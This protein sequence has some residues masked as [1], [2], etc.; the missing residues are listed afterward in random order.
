MKKLYQQ[1]NELN[2]D[3]EVEPM[4]VDEVE[5]K[6][7]KNAVLM[8]KKKSSL[9]GKLSTSVIL[10]ASVAIISITLN[11]T[12]PVLAAKLPIIGNI[13]EL[14]QKENKAYVFDEYNEYSTEIG[15]TKESSGIEITITNAVYDKESVTIAYTMKSEVDLGE[16]P[17]LD[18]P[19]LIEELDYGYIQGGLITEKIGD[20]EYAGLYITDLMSGVK[21]EKIHFRW[22]GNAVHSD[23]LKKPIEGDWSF[24]FTLDAL[25]SKERRLKN[26]HSQDGGME[27]VLYKMVS[28][29]ISTTFYFTEKVDEHL[30]QWKEENWETVMF[31]YQVKDN[32]GN[33]YNVLPN[34][35]YGD[36]KFYM[37]SRIT[38]STIDKKASFLTITPVVEIFRIVNDDGVMELVKEP[39][40]IEPIK[41]DLKK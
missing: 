25:E 9:A 30:D 2:I 5:R 13:F 27:T 29:P 6:R 15:T 14:F 7:I 11:M 3:I 10:A 8:K 23:K 41:L 31:R 12:N 39:Y 37:N 20:K 35:G 33:E 28:T 26:Y 22:D 1:F 32:L 4:H 34:G 21:P 36:S 17:Y 18:G 19:S 38:T 16:K 24:A 40:P